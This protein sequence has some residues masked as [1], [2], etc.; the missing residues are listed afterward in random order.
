MG[1]GMRASVASGVAIGSSGTR[2]CPIAW[3]RSAASRSCAGVIALGSYGSIRYPA[4]TFM[5]GKD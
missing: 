2:S 3:Y 4:G 1:K 5:S